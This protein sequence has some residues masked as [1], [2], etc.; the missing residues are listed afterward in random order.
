MAN[1]SEEQLKRKAWIEKH[2]SPA[3]YPREEKNE[4]KDN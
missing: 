2:G 3:G 1:Y 4:T